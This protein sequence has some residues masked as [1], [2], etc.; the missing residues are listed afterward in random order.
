MKENKDVNGR[1]PWMMLALFPALAAGAMADWVRV[2]T[3]RFEVCTNAGEKTARRVLEG[4][5]EMRAA[6]PRQWTRP[7]PVRVVVFGTE[8][9][10]ARVRPA[11]SA[12]AFYQSGPERDFIVSHAQS[13]ELARSLRHEYAH[14]LLQHSS[15]RI[16]TWLEE[17][18]AE[19]Y[20]TYRRTGTTGY[21]G[22][23]I[24][25]HLQKL[26]T[27]RWLSADRLMRWERGSE[28]ENIGLYYAQSW[29]LVRMLK[30]S[31]PWRERFDEFWQELEGGIAQ[32]A[33]FR[34][35]FGQDLEGALRELRVRLAT[36]P[37]V[38]SF[39][40]E[41]PAAVAERPAETMPR[42]A[43]GWMIAELHLLLGRDR[44][45]VALLEELARERA[46][47]V[48]WA[49]VR[50]MWALRQGEGAAALQ[51]LRQAAEE[52]P[53]DAGVQ[54]EYTMLLRENRAGRAEIRK[55]LERVVA[56]NADHPEARFLLGVSYADE[57]RHE[58]ALVHLERAARVLPR[59]SYFWHALALS[60]REAGRREDALR[61][62]ALARD[63]ARDPDQRKLAEAT[64][65]L[66]G[67]PPEKR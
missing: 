43:A 60:Y 50:G 22:G 44:E 67:Q 5:E 46:P 11:T 56:A 36:T 40:V 16:P 48:N 47:G 3:P 9:E 45:S 32:G 52:S 38:L 4:L 63:T 57:G 15:S 14:A 51:L 41:A 35:A 6:F 53:N 61:A 37:E 64:L 18:L 13:R 29:A 2:G 20:S 23:A 7:L 42:G 55:G 54:F 24:E 59:Q 25:T 28:P 1:G 12:A 39:A 34:G 65:A 21:V 31:A 33:A 26:N 27:E 8:G 10:Y 62:A 19:F 30:L 49:F 66:S 17:G 58:E